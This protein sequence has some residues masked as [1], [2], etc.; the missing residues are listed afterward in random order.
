[1]PEIEPASFVFFFS[2]G[3]RSWS[4]RRYVKGS[5][6]VRQAHEFPWTADQVL[7]MAGRPGCHNGASTLTTPTT[8]HGTRKK[9]V[10]STADS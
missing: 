10:I 2:K 1:V 5:L 6:N 9:S 8:S 7:E 4:A 3:P